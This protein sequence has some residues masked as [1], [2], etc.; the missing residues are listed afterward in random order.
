MRAIYTAGSGLVTLALIPAAACTMYV[1]C[2]VGVPRPLRCPR[3]DR[4]ASKHH[5]LGG[6]PAHTL[7]LVVDPNFR[8]FKLQIDS[9]KIR[10]KH[11]KGG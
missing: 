5:E 2:V 4:D 3:S 9:L 1:P 10:F 8:S 7:V 6:D 11:V